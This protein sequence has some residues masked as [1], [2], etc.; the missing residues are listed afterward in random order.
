MN[1]ELI[2]T[3]Q[4]TINRIYNIDIVI[5]FHN[6]QILIQGHMNNM[7]ELEIHIFILGFL[8]GWNCHQENKPKIKIHEE[9]M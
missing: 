5:I 9:A 7:E 3:I 1:Q 4:Y 8:N 6:N 2:N